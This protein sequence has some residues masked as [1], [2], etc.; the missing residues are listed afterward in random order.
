M[1]PR[2]HWLSA[3]E[4]WGY[5]HD[6][7]GSGENPLVDDRMVSYWMMIDWLVNGD[8]IMNNGDLIIIIR[9]LTSNHMGI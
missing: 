3:T 6:M 7:A 4:L 1:L 2:N 9:G 8:L 5:S